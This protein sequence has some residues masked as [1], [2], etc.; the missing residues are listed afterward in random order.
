[1]F[2][3]VLKSAGPPFDKVYLKA[4]IH[5][6]FRKEDVRLRKLVKDERAK[7][8]NAGC[9]IKYDSNT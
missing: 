3:K 9:D 8:A 5:P 4:D 1:M 2:V 6:V 7:P